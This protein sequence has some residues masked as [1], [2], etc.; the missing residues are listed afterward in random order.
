[1]SKCVY[2]VVFCTK[3][4]RKLFDTEETR[5][6]VKDIIKD[7]CENTLGCNLLN[8]NVLDSAVE[9]D[10]IVEPTRGIYKIIRGIKRGSHRTLIDKI[11]GI[12][13][14]V[15]TIWTRKELVRTKDGDISYAD[16]LN[17]IEK[18]RKG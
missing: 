7:L 6:L 13:T 14:R 18:Q 11:P 16:V 17:F 2:N 10:L 1:M 4:C 3:Y 9:L 8:I 12:N 5:S 15:P